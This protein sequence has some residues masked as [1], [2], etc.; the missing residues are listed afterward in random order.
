MKKINLKNQIHCPADL[1]ALYCAVLFYHRN[2]HGKDK[3]LAL[4]NT[5][6]SQVKGQ[7]NTNMPGVSKEIAGQSLKNKLEAY[8][9][10]FK[11]Q[12]D[13]SAIEEMNPDSALNEQMLESNYSPAELLKL[14]QKKKM[15]SM[16]RILK[17]GQQAM[18]QELDILQPITAGIKAMPVMIRKMTNSWST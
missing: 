10:Q 11:G 3:N 2:W 8:K 13:F 7:I 15:D 12:K 4:S 17:A 16:K 14:Q 1:V 5:D 18:Q 6:S 9:D